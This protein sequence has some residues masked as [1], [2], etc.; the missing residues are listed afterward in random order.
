MRSTKVARQ[1]CGIAVPRVPLR[2]GIVQ[3]IFG[4]CV[5]SPKLFLSVLRRIAPFRVL[6]KGV[7]ICGNTMFR[8]LIT[9]IFRGV[10]GH[11]CC[12]RGSD[13]L[14]LSFIVRCGK[15]IMPIRIGTAAKGTGDLH[16]ILGRPR[17]CRIA[18]TFGLKSCGV[19]HSNRILALP[20]CVTFLLGDGGWSGYVSVLVVRLSVPLLGVGSGGPFPGYL[21]ANT[22]DKVNTTLTVRYT[23]LNTGRVFVANHGRRHLGSIIGATGSLNTRITSCNIIS[24]TSRYAVHSFVTEYSRVTPV[25]LV[26]TGTK[27]TAE[28]RA[29][30]GVHRAFSAGINN[31]L[32][33]T[34]PTVRIFHNGLNTGSTGHVH[35]RVIVATSV[36]NCTPLGAYRSCST[37]GTTIG[38]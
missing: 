9:K 17:G 15:E 6:R 25:R 27:I 4:I 22:S 16:M 3:S 23:E 37:S 31:I 13:N 1:Y 34:L 35:G 2:T 30:R 11:L 20:L 38:A 8:G 26:F 12:F 14:R 32:G 10:K 28:H 21:V 29:R 7:D 5:Y 24:I 19:N 18:R 36:T 33:A